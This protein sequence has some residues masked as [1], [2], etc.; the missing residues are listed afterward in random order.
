MMARSL[1]C[2]ERE[3][4]SLSATD[5]QRD[6][7]ALD[8]VALH[9]MQKT[10]C[11]HCPGRTN[12]MTMR[13]GTALDIDNILRQTKVLGDGN[14]NGCECLIDFDTLDICSFPARAFECLL[15]CRDRAQSKHPRLDRPHTIGDETSHRF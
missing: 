5:A 1:N 10:R 3:R 7:S 4:Y 13:N 9:R 15:D 2:F 14:G 11:E 8:A 6:N 12:R